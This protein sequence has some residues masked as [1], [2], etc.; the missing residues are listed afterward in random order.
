MGGVIAL[1]G[2]LAVYFSQAANVS[3]NVLANGLGGL[4][5]PAIPPIA[6]RMVWQ[7]AQAVGLPICGIGGIES[8]FPGEH[9]EIFIPS[10][11]GSD[12]TPGDY[13]FRD[14]MGLGSA[15][16]LWGIIRVEQ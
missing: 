9:Y 10:A 3:Q 4:S 16:G 1:T 14:H 2:V 6:Q 11:G 13:L 7:A 12:E 5:G 8:W 15:Q